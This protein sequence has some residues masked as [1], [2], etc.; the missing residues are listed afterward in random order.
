MLASC[1]WSAYIHNWSASCQ[2]TWWW[3]DIYIIS[4]RAAC[5]ASILLTLAILTMYMNAVRNMN[6]LKWYVYTIAT[7]CTYTH[8]HTHTDTHMQTHTHTY[9]W[10]HITS[11][12]HYFNTHSPQ[13]SVNPL[14]PCGRLARRSTRRNAVTPPHVAGGVSVTGKH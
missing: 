12:N 5:F 2:P 9:S 11:T 3:T 13:I 10:V 6:A 7:S 4:I 14:Y 1:W 8:A